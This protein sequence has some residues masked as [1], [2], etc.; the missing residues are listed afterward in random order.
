MV[1]ICNSQG[2]VIRRS[3]NLRG[4]L[5]HAR[6]TWIEEASA[7]PAQEGKGILSVTFGD[8]STCTTEFASYEVLCWWLR[9][10]RSWSGVRR[11]G[12]DPLF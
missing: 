6:R 4:I 10:R 5:D 1:E 8:R 7:A 3:R 9:S 11:I 2:Q 12:A